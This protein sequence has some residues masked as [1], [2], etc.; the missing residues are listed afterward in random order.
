MW[1]FFD[2]ALAGTQNERPKSLEDMATAS[3]LILKEY[4]NLTGLYARLA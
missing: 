3:E 2:V 4:E 1:V